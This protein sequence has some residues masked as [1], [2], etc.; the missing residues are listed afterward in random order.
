MRIAVLSRH[1]VAN[2]GGAERYAIEVVE[3][4]AAGNDV[5]V[6]AQRISHSYPGV[7][8]HLLPISLERPRW[9]NQLLFSYQVWRATRKGFDIVHS[10]E[11]VWHGNVQAVHVLPVKY[12]LF[13]GRTGLGLLLQ[14]LRVATSPRL[15]TYLW[16][17]RMR[18]APGNRRRVVVA[19]ST[20][21]AAMEK[22]YPDIRQSL[23]V[24]TP[25]VDI[26]D[27]VPGA[28]RDARRAAR[29]ALRLPM[30]GTCVLF[31][32]NDF[33]KKGLPALIQALAQLGDVAPGSF[34]AVAGN[35][36]QRETMQ[37]LASE[38]GVEDRL[39]FLGALDQMDTA[40]RA[41]D[42]L[43]HPTLQDSYAMVVLEAMAYRL[44]V[45]VS[46]APYCGISDDLTHGVNALLIDNPQDAKAI[47]AHL[48]STLTDQHL[49]EKLIENGLV[50]AKRHTWKAAGQA[51]AKLFEEVQA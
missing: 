45:I 33:R 16:L 32:G 18:F 11:N 3:Q 30:E 19:S 9:I 20:L 47:A 35:P 38:L 49:R 37:A 22:V 40:Y 8:Y 21:A 7:T 39:F 48:R 36:A 44:P 6:F 42:C 29:E 26:P 5:H 28:E 17:E 25:G 13:N 34:L 15:L 41:A 1:F 31:I 51:H 10:H 50:F 46:A 43:V 12:G 14:R 24:I 2:G 4:L 23:A 27:P